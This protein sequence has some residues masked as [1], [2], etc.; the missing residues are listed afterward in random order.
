MCAYELLA[1]PD[2]WQDTETEP[3]EERSLL[4]HLQMQLSPENQQLDLPIPRG[5]SRKNKGN[6]QKKY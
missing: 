4:L 5:I 3:I 1:A 6:A 2:L